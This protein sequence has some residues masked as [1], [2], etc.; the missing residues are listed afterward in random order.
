MYYVACCCADPE[1]NCDCA[2]YGYAKV[3]ARIANFGTNPI[4]GYNTGCDSYCRTGKAWLFSTFQ[5]T[6]AELTTYMKCTGIGG[7]HPTMFA[8]GGLPDYRKTFDPDNFKY[9]AS[10]DQLEMQTF[11][12]LSRPCFDGPGFPCQEDA[13]LN[14][15]DNCC[16][17]GQGIAG[18]WLYTD[19]TQEQ[20]RA[21]SG[22]NLIGQWPND[23]GPPRATSETF[24]STAGNMPAGE[25]VTEQLDPKL[26]YRW[27]KVQMRFESPDG[28]D[29][30]ETSSKVAPVEPYNESEYQTGGFN[31][32][33]T[34]WQINEIGDEC[35]GA[36]VGTP[37]ISSDWNGNFNYP[38]ES[39]DT[40]PA[41]SGSIEGACC[42]EGAESDSSNSAL[43]MRNETNVIFDLEFTNEPPDPW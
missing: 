37:V 23:D 20:K 6:Y 33:I 36:A 39:S 13:C 17:N 38:E 25:S 7:G 43:V 21:E 27:I 28:Y 2:G 31:G 11:T 19:R 35:D 4:S 34:C 5:S 24:V 14:L 15:S 26:F 8:S 29:R 32:I 22:H 40:C 3:S 9:F 1:P 42:G 16:D 12:V 10:E 18:M 30:L 41:G